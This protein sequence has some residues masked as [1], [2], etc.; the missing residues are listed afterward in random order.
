VNARLHLDIPL[1]GE[2]TTAKGDVRLNNN[3]LFIKPLDSTI[4]N[5]SGQF[6]FV[7]GNLKSGPLTASWFKQP[8]NIDFSTTEGEKAYQVA[9][10]L[11]AN[12]QPARMDVVPKPISEAVSGSLPWKG[13][14]AI[15]LPYRG[16]TQYKVD[17]TSDLKNV[18]SHLP[19]PLDKSAGEALPVNIKVDGNLSSFTL[20][21]SAGDNNHFNSRW[22]LNRKLTLDRAIWA[23]DSRTL[24]PLPE[25]PGVEL[26]LPPMDGAEWL[27]LLQK[28]VG[29]NV[30]DAA[31]FPQL[32]TVRTPALT[33]GGQ[34]WN[35]LSIVSQPTANGSKVEARG[36]EINATLTMRDTAPWQADIRYL[37]FNPASPQGS[38]GSSTAPFTVNKRID[39]TGLPDLQLRCAECWLWGQKYGRVDGDFAIN[40][41]TLSLSGGLLD[42]GF[43]RMTVN[44]EWVNGVSEQRTSLKGQI[45]G[46]KLDAATGFFGL[47]TPIRDSRFN[48][49]YDLH[50]RNPP[51]QPDTAS[52]NGIL[53]VQ[54]GKGEITDVSTGRA[55]QLLRLVSF[56]AL[57]RKL[58]FDFSDTFGEGFYFDS[59][60]STAWIKEGVLH[61]DDT[62]VDGLE[63]DIAMKGSV[64][65]VRRELD[66]EAVVAPEISATVGVAA[67]FVVN[68][69]VG[70]AVF[71]AS[72]VLGP[73]WSKV[74][75]LRY[76]ITG[77]VDKPQINEV[78]RQARK[79]AQQ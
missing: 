79:D 63:A 51:W 25:Q 9:V 60:N 2:M 16:G 64:N 44:G 75:I 8:V 3:N 37:Y 65:L 34:Q 58:R 15:D 59:I 54:L 33:L 12:W 52:L 46:N 17:I 14:V 45:K 26:N 41:N 36:R 35:N 76:R 77:P 19:S 1:D 43:G 71:A 70:A 13:K 67:A 30:D 73:L 39:F 24:P 31:Q 27:G 18:S 40:G 61:T 32:I 69:I 5:L 66:M 23:S 57:L 50:W 42:T 4:N 38:T 6:S 11:D 48:V 55:G 68:P 53:K 74:S 21:G 72:K 47:T 28:G 56:D 78:L 22:L 62:L 7:N 29:K 10:N 20:T 49:D